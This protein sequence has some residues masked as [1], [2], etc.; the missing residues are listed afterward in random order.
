MDSEL[1]K[2][3]TNFE[4]ENSL[5]Q[6]DFQPTNEGNPVLSASLKTA[7][8]LDQRDAKGKR[9]EILKSLKEREI[10]G[11]PVIVR[12]PKDERSSQKEIETL[13]KWNDTGLGYIPLQ[14]DTMKV[15]LD[16]FKLT[17]KIIGEEFERLGLPAYKPLDVNRIHFIGN[18]LPWVQRNFNPVSSGNYVSKQQA[19]YVRKFE[20]GIMKALSWIPAVKRYSQMLDAKSI[21][22]ESIHA[23]GHRKFVSAGD[24]G[25]PEE[26]RVGYSLKRNLGEELKMVGFNEA[27]VQ[28]LTIELM[29]RN[30]AKFEGV[31]GFGVSDRIIEEMDGY[32]KYRKILDQIINKVAE[33]KSLSPDVVKDEIY[34]GHFTGEMMHLRGI[35]EV[36]G[37][38]SLEILS[39]LH[40]QNDRKLLKKKNEL[41]KRYFFA[42]SSIERE[43][44]KQK[45]VK[46]GILKG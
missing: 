11:F 32:E 43:K 18:K 8:E 25:E 13:R 20:V 7:V 35:E 15:D 5:H 36:F 26:Y 24:A 3:S 37:K 12:S 9:V 42:D 46:Q 34:R 39:L 40:D 28:T 4:D 23:A 29:K 31:L 27:V 38:D 2:L 30:R 19:V 21:L 6:L 14:G 44:I 45:L 1:E 33:R 22:H 16:T 10:Q 17:N 41:V